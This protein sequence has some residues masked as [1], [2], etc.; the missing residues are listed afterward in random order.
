M[1]TLNKILPTQTEKPSPVTFFGNPVLNNLAS[2][3]KGLD[4]AEF[5][6]DQKKMELEKQ[7][8]QG[9]ADSSVPRHVTNN[10]EVNVS[11]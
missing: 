4:F 5:L 11:N 9:K 2:H 1:S 3:L 10:N 6:V 7:E 8:Q